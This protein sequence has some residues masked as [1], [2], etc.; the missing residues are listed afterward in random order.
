M[1]KFENV[2]VVKKEKQIFTMVEKLQVELLNLQ[3]VQEKH[4]EL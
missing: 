2:T 4:L 3:M 1:S